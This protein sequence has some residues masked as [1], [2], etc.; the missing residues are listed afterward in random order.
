MLLIAQ[1]VQYAYPRG[2]YCEW[3]G[4]NMYELFFF[5]SRMVLVY[6]KPA[7]IHHT[8]EIRNTNINSEHRLRAVHNVTYCPKSISN[9]NK[10]NGKSLGHILFSVNF[11]IDANRI[12]F[13]QVAIGHNEWLHDFPLIIADKYPMLNTQW[14]WRI[15]LIQF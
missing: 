15:H 13:F 10:W 14:S 3:I 11:N 2:T 1:K 7:C 4:S 8:L 9:V 5:V 6:W 12:D